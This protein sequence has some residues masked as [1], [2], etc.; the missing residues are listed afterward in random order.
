MCNTT[1]YF[2]LP[3]FLRFQ[4]QNWHNAHCVISMPCRRKC[5][6]LFLFLIFP[7]IVLLNH[8][9]RRMHVK[10]LCFPIYR[11]LHEVFLLWMAKMHFPHFSVKKE[12]LL[13]WWFFW[14]LFH[15][16][17][18][19]KGFHQC[20]FSMTLL[21]H[22]S[23]QLWCHRILFKSVCEWDHQHPDPLVGI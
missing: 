21:C 19:N 23:I 22:P 20:L 1:S 14:F 7:I 3:F 13:R 5:L 9:M 16:L 2:L 4:L 6:F 18:R 12:R 15:C 10:T 8:R 11:T 17:R